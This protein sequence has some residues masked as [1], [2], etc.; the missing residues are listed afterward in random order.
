MSKPHPHYAMP[1]DPEIE[2]V[3]RF[4]QVKRWH[5]IDTVRIQ[6]LAEHSASVGLLA[7]IIAKTTPKMYFGSGAGMAVLG[8]LHD[9]PE[10][11]TGDIPTPTKRYL[12]GLDVLEDQLL[13]S[14][15]EEPYIEQRQ[16]LL[17]K[18]CDLA[19]GVRFLV[20]HSSGE[21]AAHA[22]Q[23]LET[24]LRDRFDLAYA[25]W[26]ADVCAHVINKLGAY[27]GRRITVAARIRIEDAPDSTDHVA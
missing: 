5:M 13:P 20:T 3:K 23:G 12:T 10:V 7:Y 25:E 17:I 1:T 18:L 15:F 4:S 19:D 14:T 26:P 6:T 8:L 9:L 2:T 24:Q 11:F 27:C 21:I 22:L 16:G